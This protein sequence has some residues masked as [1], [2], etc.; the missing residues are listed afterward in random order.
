M[1][2]KHDT[3]RLQCE[4]ENYKLASFCLI[5]IRGKCK[6]TNACKTSFAGTSDAAR[7]A[8]G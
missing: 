2:K 4:Y 1:F 5:G 7:H 6:R 8:T 3:K